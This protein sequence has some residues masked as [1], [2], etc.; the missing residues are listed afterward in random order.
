MNLTVSTN[1]QA[2]CTEFLYRE[3][4]YLDDRRF[5]DWIHLLTEDVTYEVP[6]RITR[7]FGVRDLDFNNNGFHMKDSFRSLAM[8]VERLY[9]ERAYAEDPPS[10]TTRLVTNI[11]VQPRASSAEVDVKSNFSCYRAQGEGTEF[12]LFMGERR[13]VLRLVDGH[14][15]L[16]ARRVLLAHTTLPAPIGL[17]F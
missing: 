11:R 7:G 1:I 17:F 4:E 14:L 10:R 13:D 6:I 12:A 16:A 8:R 15:K 9:T 2:Q 3:S 5:R